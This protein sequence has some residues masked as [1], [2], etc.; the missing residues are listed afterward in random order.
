MLTI[1]LN[2]T[3]EVLLNFL[4]IYIEHKIERLNI[5]KKIKN[6]FTKVKEI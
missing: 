1:R 6:I 2:T 3:S 4:S 5:D